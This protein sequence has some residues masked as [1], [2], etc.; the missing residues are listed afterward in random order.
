VKSSEP[1]P[2]HIA[3]L[4]SRG[5]P[6]RYGGFE[7]F[8]ERLSQRLVDKGYRVSAYC[9]RAFTRP[10]D[11]ELVDPRIRRVILPSITTKH[12][13]TPLHTFLSVLHVV[14]T[15]A[16]L[17]LMV[18]AANS[19][20]AWLPRLA[21]KPVV[22][23]VDGLDRTRKKWGWLASSVLYICELISL[24]TPTRVVTDARA[25]QEYYQRRY[26]KRSTMI[27]YGADAPSAAGSAATTE[28]A[29]RGL[30][31]GNYILYVSRMEP[32]NNPELVLLAYQ[33]LKTDWPLVMVGGNSYDQQYD[34]R[35]RSLATPGVFFTG[36]VYGDGYWTLQKNAGMFIFGCE[37]GGV[38][39][40]LVEAMAAARPVLYLDTES[41][42]ETANGCGIVF[43]KNEGDLATN[44]SALIADPHRRSQLGQAA[45]AFARQQYSWENIT[46]Q[47]EELFLELRPDAATAVAR[48]AEL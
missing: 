25:I 1:K 42:R 43:A 44:M 37:V 10:E 20:F 23:N 26:G 13:D 5:I 28:L 22:L 31:A 11:S 39:P 24:F 29:S 35:L 17:V 2:L 19:P 9:R 30:K 46:Q 27:A 6:N 45:A 7:A 34:A 3:I 48:K 12:L 16:D 14:F 18:N 47:Y 36:P 4:G 15:D 38:H 8:A 33:K 21:G 32:E 41:N 40:A